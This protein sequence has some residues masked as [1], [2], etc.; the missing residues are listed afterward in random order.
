MKLFEKTKKNIDIYLIRG[1][2][3]FGI[4]VFLSVKNT[5]NGN[6]RYYIFGRK[7]NCLYHLE[8]K[9]DYRKR[10][11]ENKV[12][13]EDSPKISVIVNLA[14]KKK[15]CEQTRLSLL[16]QTYRNFEVVLVSNLH[17]D[18]VFENTNTLSSRNEFTVEAG[19]KN[20][21][22]E[23]IAFCE[24][25]EYWS[26]NYLEKKVEIIGEYR[27]PVV[28]VNDIEFCGSEDSSL[29]LDVIADDGREFFNKKINRISDALWKEHD[30]I[31]SISCCMIKKTALD[32]CNFSEVF[33]QSQ[34]YGW[35]LRQ[36]FNKNDFIYVNEKLT[37]VKASEKKIGE[38][39]AD[40]FYKRFQLIKGDYFLG[41]KRKAAVSFPD[42][43]H[44]IKKEFGVPDRIKKLA[45][46][47]S[48][49]QKSIIEDYVV[50]YLKELSQI[51]DG[52]IFVMDNPVLDG[53]IDKIQ[54]YVTYVQ[55]ERHNEY[56][57]GSYKRGWS[58]LKQKDFFKDVEELI[59]CNDSCYGPYTPLNK[60][61]YE[62]NARGNSVDFWG[63]H[64]NSEIC[65][66][67][68][69]FFY[70]FK[71][72]VFNNPVFDEFILAVKE[73]IDVLGVILNYEARFTNILENEGFLWDTYVD[74]SI[75]DVSVKQL[76]DDGCPLIKVK[77]IKEIYGKSE[78]NVKGFRSLM[79]SINPDLLK[80]IEKRKRFL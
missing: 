36:T 47:A 5:L 49:S 69:S 29:Y 12:N 74:Y 68:Q 66:H 70:V 34:L 7:I 18:D 15:L 30:F 6:R 72:Q 39:N 71:K 63:I 3:I 73:E 22:G 1:F 50:Y 37:F 31:L 38:L 32:A 77:K 75:I 33:H 46:F 61:F 58:Y 62:M 52:I 42:N 25:G 76:A 14:E 13:H 64:R 11:L 2:L 43:S 78:Q 55:C 26:E 23:Y 65:D 10:T 20:S 8:T 56:D 48:F 60:V 21:V 59:L 17:E 19:I 67:I 24:N 35:I 79:N 44:N 41:H 53:E 16:N 54:K 57:F 51:V 4:N 80:I 40:S 9:S 28:I 27:N 45:I